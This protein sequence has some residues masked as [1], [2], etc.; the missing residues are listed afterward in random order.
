MKLICLLSK[1]QKFEHRDLVISEKRCMQNSQMAQM[2]Q[3]EKSIKQNIKRTYKTLQEVEVAMEAEMR[4][5][6]PRKK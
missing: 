2:A 3:M 1:L 5:K 4:D 6:S